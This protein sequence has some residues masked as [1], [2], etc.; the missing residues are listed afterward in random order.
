MVRRALIQQSDG[1]QHD[2]QHDRHVNEPT[3]KFAHGDSPGA[4]S[5]PLE[6]GVTYTD[7]LLRQNRTCAGCDRAPALNHSLSHEPQ[8]CPGHRQRTPIPTISA[9]TRPSSLKWLALA[10]LDLCCLMQLRH[11]AGGGGRARCRKR[12]REQRRYGHR[13][14]HDQNG[15]R[16]HSGGRAARR[17]LEAGVHGGLS[18][19]GLKCW[20]RLGVPGPLTPPY[21]HRHADAA[22]PD[23]RRL[24]TAGARVP[25]PRS[26][27]WA[28]GLPWAGPAATRFNSG[29]RAHRRLARP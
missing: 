25:P 24:R 1:L 28:V 26:G 20:R 17:G 11:L 27:S 8:R 3:V 29:R 21:F 16:G 12:R 9:A 2:D 23:V 10:L 6:A 7:S 14:D 18:S 15:G 13:E 4:A 22:K 5:R 19:K